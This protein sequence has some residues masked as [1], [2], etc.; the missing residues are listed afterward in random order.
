MNI[1]DIFGSRT[2]HENAT[3]GATGTPNVA[4]AIS[5]LG[6]IGVG[7][8]PN[9]DKGIYSDAKPKKQKPLLI[10]RINENAQ[11]RIGSVCE[12]RTNF[13]DADF[14]MIRKGSEKEVGKP[15]YTF[16]KEYIGIKVI[17]TNVL[18]PKYLF[19]LIQYMHS[20]GLFKQMSTGSLKLVH[21]TVNQI[22]SIPLNQ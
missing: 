16:D 19:Y 20:R 13:P 15:T 11:I 9:G 4:T 21:I 2:I 8:D 18:D 1:N 3:T 10:K 5:A 12:V 22:K 7:F 14:W 6:G 17:E